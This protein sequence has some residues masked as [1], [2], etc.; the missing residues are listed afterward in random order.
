MYSKLKELIKVFTPSEKRRFYRLQLV[1]VFMTMF[2]I[3]SIA[4]FGPFF[5]LISD[6]GILDEDNKLAKLYELS[7]LTKNQFVFYC[8]LLVIFL[9]GFSSF[10]SIRVNWALKDFNSTYVMRL[11][12]RLFKFYLKKDYLFHVSNSSSSLIKQSITET[13][14]VGDGVAAPLVQLVANSIFIL[15]VIL[16]LILYKPMV[17]VLG[18]LFLTIIYM[19]IYWS[20]KNKMK[21]NGQNITNKSLLRTKLALNS[22]VGVRDILQMDKQEFFV[23]RF[24]KAS[25]SF[26]KSQTINIMFATFPKYIVEFIALGG[27]VLM[28]ILF[29]D[30]GSSQFSEILPVLIVFALLILKLIPAFQMVF[31]SLSKIKANLAAFES[32]REDLMKMIEQ[33]A[34]ENKLED[35]KILPFNKVL[36]IEDLHYTYPGERSKVLKGMNLSIERNTTIGFAGYSGA[37]KSTIVDILNGLLPYQHG[38]IKVDGVALNEKTMAQFKR[39]IGFVSQS[40]F[41]M[42]ATIKENIA[43]GIEHD[44]ID[45]DKIMRLIKQVNLESLLVDLPMGIE[46]EIGERGVQLSGGQVQ[47]IAIARALYKESEIL[48]FD[49][50]TSALDGITEEKILDSIRELK[51]TKTIIMIAHRLTTLKS[52]DKIYILDK[53][54][55]VSEGSFDELMENDQ[56]FKEML[57]LK[58]T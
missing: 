23:K 34:E 1:V 19:I 18:G 11:S 10:L 38:T 20:T 9:V 7:G 21:V 43:F 58:T 36:E 56:I 37:G 41:L 39:N 50:A 51:G 26:A 13:R 52:C 31:G 15:L 35:Q 5:S 44:K 55:I 46:T 45:E 16:V 40:I 22:F 6:L 8:G 57:K 30:S 28:M 3:V 14:R 25:D 4:S 27:I 33:E 54:K 48:I 53:G 47:R 49:E 29:L 2:Q 17:T 42:D 32:L 12:S 24:A